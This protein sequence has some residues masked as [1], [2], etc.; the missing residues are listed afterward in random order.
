MT[1]QI[2][3]NLPMFGISGRTLPLREDLYM[4][5]QQEEMVSKKKEM[6]SIL[7]YHSINRL[8]IKPYYLSFTFCEIFQNIEY[9]IIISKK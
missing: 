8:H 6:V 4:D 3:Y 2:V 1:A 7:V 9:E 5:I